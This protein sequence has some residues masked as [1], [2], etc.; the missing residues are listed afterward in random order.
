MRASPAAQPQPLVVALA[1]GELA[2]A[3]PRPCRRSA[4]RTARRSA[5]SA[6]SRARARSPSRP[7]VQGLGRRLQVD[8]GLAR[9]GDAVQQ[10]AVAP[11]RPR[12]S[13]AAPPAWSARQRR[14]AR[15]ARRPTR[16]AARGATTRGAIATSPRPSSR[17]SAAVSARRE[18][19]QRAQQLALAVGQ[20]LALRDAAA[21]PPAYSARLARAIP[22]AGAGATAPAP[23]SSVLAR[24]PQRELDEVR[25]QRR[26]EHA[27]A[28]RR[29]SCSERLG[30]PGHDADHVAAAERARRA[31]IRRRRR[32][33]ARSRTARAAR[34][35]W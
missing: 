18:A 12:G 26:L 23:G 6:R 22:S 20:P 14:R 7:R 32:P 34:G 5:A 13:R 21:R 29:R 17:R 4:P 35:P 3:G 28:A 19:R 31:P 1:G 8:L 15:G 9:P 10:Q 11:A 16:A 2:S 30:E 24:D 25:R 27:R 33:G